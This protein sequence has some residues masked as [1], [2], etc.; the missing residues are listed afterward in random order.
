MRDFAIRLQIVAVVVCVLGTM[1]AP[2]AS[3][4]DVLPNLEPFPA[5]DVQ[6]TD[7]GNTLRFSA[8]SWNRGAGPMELNGGEIISPGTP[9]EPGQQRVYQRI[10]QVDGTSRLVEAG[11]F[12]YHG[13]NHN[14]FHF[15]D[16][17]QYTLTPVNAPGG[18]A[19]T[20]QK[21]SFC[22]LDNLKVNTRLP[23]APKKAVYETCNPFVQGISVGWGDIYA[24]FLDGQSIDFTG[25]PSGDYLLTIEVNPISNVDGVRHLVESNTTDN[26]AC[27]LVRINV[28]ALTA[29]VIDTTCN[30]SYG[31]VTVA[32]MS[33]STLRAGSQT[34]VTI[35]GTG[36][37]NGIDVH[38]DHGSG[39]VPV[40]SNIQVVSDTKIT[41][42]VTVPSGAISSDPVWDLH[43]G[44]AVL[45]DALIVTR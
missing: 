41:A 38:F 32:S 34:T 20:S 15:E 28:T 5:S 43:V 33:P 4:Q 11:I 25:N 7:G 36:F 31:V 37:G 3:A 16:F 35:L 17:A 6:L 27:A 40:A 23:N 29:Q 42:T 10:Y 45:A 44:P 39:K 1:S 9:T 13:G 8:S 12:E 26:I 19:R 18:T 24:S 21:V 22:L 30:P 14:H 2:S